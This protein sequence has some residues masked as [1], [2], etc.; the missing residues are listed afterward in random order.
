MSNCVTTVFA[1]YVNSVLRKKLK[2]WYKVN[3]FRDRQMNDGINLSLKTD[4][5]IGAMV[6]I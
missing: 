3:V 5:Q 1:S 2:Y 4:K 6:N